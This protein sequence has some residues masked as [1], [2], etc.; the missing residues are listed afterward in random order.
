MLSILISHAAH[1]VYAGSWREFLFQ[2]G[3]C[4]TASTCL[5]HVD[6]RSI[7]LVLLRDLRD[8]HLRGAAELIRTLFDMTVAELDE[9][10]CCEASL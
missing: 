8:K 6:F 4:I 7:P 10:G 5:L 2:A 9:L 1:H 3:E